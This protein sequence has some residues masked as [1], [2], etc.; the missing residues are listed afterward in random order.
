MDAAI[1]VGLSKM[2]HPG[3]IRLNKLEG[4]SNLC[5]PASYDYDEEPTNRVGHTKLLQ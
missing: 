5:S 4:F 1:R 3:R 2:F